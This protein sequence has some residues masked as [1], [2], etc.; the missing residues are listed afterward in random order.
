MTR[1]VADGCVQVQLL[2]RAY[3]VRGH[4]MANLDPLHISDADLDSRIPPELKLEYY[5]WTEKDLEK[6]FKVSEGILPR[7][8]GHVE[9]DTM[10]LGQIID[11]LKRMYCESQ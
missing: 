2:V 9:N 7:Y 11:E 1:K 6:K 4:N 10:S 8:V 3:Q 5:G